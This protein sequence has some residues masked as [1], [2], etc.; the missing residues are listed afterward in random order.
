MSVMKN[1]DDLIRY[2]NRKLKS[3]IGNTAKQ[4]ELI[5]ELH[6]EFNIPI[7]LA[8]DYITMRIDIDSATDFICYVF[9]T[10][11]DEKKLNNFFSNSEIEKYRNSK[12]AEKKLSFP[13]KFNMI[14]ISEDQWIGKISVKELMK[15]R[16]A[17]LINYNENA[18]RTMERI[19]SGE[20]EYY[21]IALNK[22]AVEGIVES[23]E[24]ETYI[25]NTITLNIPDG[26]DFYYEDGK[27]FIRKVDH[28]DIL[29]GY[30][31]Y[32][33]ISKIY[34]IRHSFDYSMELRIVNF[35]E[36][37]AKQFIWQ[38][39][40]KT[41]MKKIDS[42]SL[43]QNNSANKIVQRLNSDSTCNLASMI[44]RNKGIV[45]SA[46]LGQAISK[47]YMQNITKKKA[48]IKTIEITKELKEKINYVT[49]QDISLL[50]KSWSRKFIICF[51]Y[52][53]SKLEKEE[54]LNETNRLYS[55]LQK[56]ENR[57][58]FKQSEISTIDLTRLSK[59]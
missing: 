59:L 58:I 45:N 24:N 9:L 8:S 12:Y 32:I 38:E 17:Q 57:L 33:A 56:E 21:R 46:Y 3:N 48:V 35:P 52:C 47:I 55:E 41:R 22:Q 1:R 23:Y 49:E 43:N 5:K 30:H 6:S 39:D 29:D 36:D 15:L 14:Q 54:V 7:S 53:C 2:L 4:Q 11:F 10:R 44:S 34:N 26:S 42:D 25:P 51:V 37:K 28:L 18:Q 16:D 20:T 27:L 31:R 50:D 19:I 40:Q 13:L